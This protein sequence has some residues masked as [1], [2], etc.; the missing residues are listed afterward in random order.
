MC[1]PGHAYEPDEAANSFRSFPVNPARL[2]TLL[3]VN[4]K[5]NRGMY[6]VSKPNMVQNLALKPKAKTHNT[7]N[8]AEER[9]TLS[10][11]YP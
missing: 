3:E 11:L 2:P 9:G 8:G 4:A 6:K 10:N 5:H 1:V 7:S